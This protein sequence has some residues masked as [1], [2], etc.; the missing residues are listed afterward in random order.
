MFIYEASQII[1]NLLDEFENLAKSIVWT[2]LQH[3]VL[4]LEEG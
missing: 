1:R 3:F 2:E 4:Q